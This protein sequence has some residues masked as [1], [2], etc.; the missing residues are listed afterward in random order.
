MSSTRTSSVIRVLPHAAL[1]L[2]LFGAGLAPAHAQQA[3]PETI[4][5]LRTELAELKA[6]QVERDRR[7]Q[8]L[9]DALQRI[10]GGPATSQPVAATPSAVAP[11]A[12]GSTSAPAST[13]AAAPATT[14]AAIASRLKVS[15]D[16][17]LRGQGDWSDDDAPDRGS[18][19]IRGR[20]GATFAVND[21]V[22][23]GARLA[24]GDADDPNSTDVQLSNWLDDLD[25]SLDMAYVQFNFDKLTLYGGKF[26]NPFVRSDL[27]WD[28]DVN[29]Q[30]IGAIWRQPL[31]GGGTLRANGLAFVVDEQAAGSDSTMLGAQ[32]GYTSAKRGDWTFDAN[33]A[34]YHYA[35][36]STAGADSGDFRSNLRN[37]DG[38]YLSQFHLANVL[39]GTTWSGLGEQW[40]LRLGV[41]YVHNTGAATDADTGYGADLSL[42]KASAPGDWRFTYGYSMAQADAVLA[43]FSHDNIGFGTNYRLH[44]LTV[45]YVPVPKTMLSLY[46]Y[47]YR[48]YSNLYPVGQL[49]NDWLDRLRLAFLV[50]F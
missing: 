8:R 13:P 14:S 15:G 35:L 6:E 48:P 12:S 41:D 42:G 46:W 10:A 17:R 26:A 27:V 40:P 45:D 50:N 32:L 3:A 25:V 30:G 38:S 2:A 21:R 22:T 9:E 23:V 39:V 47:H 34:Y 16:L 5:A 44:G 33:A 7:I 36:G 37:P 20:L 19:Q 31:A 29:P 43:A 24:T 28:G 49:P 11:T 4:D 18:M 1:S